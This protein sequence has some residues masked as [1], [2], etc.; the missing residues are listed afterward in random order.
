MNGNE[1]FLYQPHKVT[2]I[3]ISMDAANGNS[4]VWVKYLWV[5][6]L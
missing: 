5:K 6:R 1:M 2:L 3:Y 4:M